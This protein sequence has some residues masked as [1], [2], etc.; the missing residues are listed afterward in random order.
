V[1]IYRKSQTEY[2]GLQALLDR[3]DHLRV[4]LSLLVDS[5][6]PDEVL[7]EELRKE[8]SEIEQQIAPNQRKI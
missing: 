3:R 5:G 8:L 1:G 2:A 4:H 6:K 7:L